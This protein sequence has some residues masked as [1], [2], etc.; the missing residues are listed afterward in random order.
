MQWFHWVSDPNAWVALLTL[1]AMEIVLG[2]DNVVF[3]SILVGQVPPENRERIRRIGL[4]LAL[5]MRIALLLGIEWIMSLREPVLHA[6]GRGFS[7]RDLILIAGGLF[8]L[9]KSTKEIHGTV[10][11][12]E[13]HHQRVATKVAVILAQIVLIDVV[14]SLDSVITAVGMADDIPVM[15]IA[16]VIA[17]IAMMMFAKSIGD[18]VDEHP[19]VKVLA[20]AFLILIGIVLVADGLGEHIAKGYV[21]FAMAFSLVVELLNLRL[22][23]KRSSATATSPE[24]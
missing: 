14:F 17:V 19:T 13:E 1:A 23:K 7:G 12:G 15:I 2:I 3:I 8:L 5:G 4:T 22:R 18:F 10:E 9:A 6:A 21:Y 20:L 16:M 24:R 11:G